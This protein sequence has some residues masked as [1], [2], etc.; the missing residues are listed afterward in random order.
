MLSVTVGLN[1]YFFP[2]LEYFTSTPYD[3]ANVYQIFQ[4][5]ASVF[6]STVKSLLTIPCPQLD[7]M[8]YP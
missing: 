6:L 7:Y 3:L 1:A 8:R 4:V 5:S 2:F